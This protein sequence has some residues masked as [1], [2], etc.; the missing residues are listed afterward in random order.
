MIES[1]E[2]YISYAQSFMVKSKLIGEGVVL[3][4]KLQQMF[5]S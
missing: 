3:V 4:N 5:P 2:V 1:L